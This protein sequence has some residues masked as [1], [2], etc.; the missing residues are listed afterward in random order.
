MVKCLN[1]SVLKIDIFQLW[2]NFG[3]WKPFDVVK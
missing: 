2:E 3:K 1:V